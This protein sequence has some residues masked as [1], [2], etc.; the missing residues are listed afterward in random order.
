MGNLCILGA[1]FVC[2][3]IISLIGILALSLSFDVCSY[4]HTGSFPQM[5]FATLHSKLYILRYYYNVIFCA[6][7]VSLQ[8]CYLCYLC[9]I[10]ANCI[11]FF[12]DFFFFCI[13]MCFSCVCCCCC[14]GRRCVS[15]SLPFVL[16]L[17]PLVYIFI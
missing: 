1:P 11:L 9:R 4:T 2:M 16:S 3:H 6:P 12:S 13:Y 5:V 10:L 7:I 15:L 14:R 17:L 8:Y